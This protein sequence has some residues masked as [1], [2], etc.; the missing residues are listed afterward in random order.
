MLDVGSAGAQGHSRNALLW[1]SIFGKLIP[2]Q[3]NSEEEPLDAGCN[4]NVRI[5]S[6]MW[7][8]AIEVEVIHIPH[9]HIII[10]FWECE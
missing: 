8:E 5:Q 4:S 6:F 1:S 2:P 3:F 10:V 7:M 9:F